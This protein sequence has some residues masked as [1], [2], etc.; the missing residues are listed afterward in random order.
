MRTAE[1]EPGGTA[2]VGDWLDVA[3]LPG[4]PPRRGQVLEVLG[5]PDHVHYRV[6]WDEQH[7]SIFFPADGVHVIHSERPD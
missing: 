4:K 1:H 5:A 6:R 7:E 3:G 2:Q